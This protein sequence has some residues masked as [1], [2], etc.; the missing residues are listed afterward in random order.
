MQ[1]LFKALRFASEDDYVLLHS[2]CQER[3]L[4]TG[5]QLFDYED[6]ADTL[7]FLHNGRLAVHK[8]SGFQ[9]KMQVVALLDTGTVVAEG[10]V[11]EGHVHKCKVTAVDDCILSSLSH[12]AYCQFREKAPDLAFLLF[13]YLFKI[14]SLRLEKST[15]R[16]A[17]IL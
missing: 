12:K 8:Y 10:A 14:A 1:L 5:E 4:A 2:F 11:I 13:E 9:S 17:R 7:F 16:M 6:D 3:K 15:E